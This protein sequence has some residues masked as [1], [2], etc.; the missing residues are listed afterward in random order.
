MSVKNV[1][2]SLK[3][4][5]TIVDVFMEN[6][7][8]YMMMLSFAQ[9]VLREASS[10]SPQDREM[11]AAYTSYLNGCRYCYGSHRLF[12]E[13]I[14]AEIEVLDSGI[15]SVPNRLT[16]IFNLVEQLTKHPSSMT[17]KLYDECYNAGFTQEQVKD[18]VAVCA[19]FNFFNRIVE[20]HGVQ[21]NSES[22]APAAEQINSMGY[23]R[24]F[25]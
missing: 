8:K 2:D 25:A 17:K 7:K 14:N 1:F 21:E 5:A 24:R 20:G 18:A 23:D 4:N 3:E 9:E 10:L 11:V 13:S 6:Q 15:Q 19:A 16:P 12:A 22:W